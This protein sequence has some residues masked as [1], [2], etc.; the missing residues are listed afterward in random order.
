MLNESGAEITE[1]V[2]AELLQKKREN[3]NRQQEIAAQLMG[4]SLGGGKSTKSQSLEDL[5]KELNAL[6]TDYDSIE[7]QIRSASPRYAALT[8]PRPLTLEDIRQQVLDDQ[9]AL[10]EY[11]LGDERSYLFAVTRNGFT[12]S[13]L[14][15]RAEIERQTAALRAQI[16]PASLRRS[17]TDMVSAAIDPQPGLSVSGGASASPAVASA[18]APAASA[19][20]KTGVEPAAPLFKQSRLLVVA[21]GALNYVPFHALVTE[22]PSG[23]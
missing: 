5:E 11:K 15:G 18:F 4:V 1:G 6:Q 19:L 21:D 16:I 7:N 20:Y 3:Q 23:A 14:P 12:L 17:I 8:A 13:R 2:P 10:L 22:A 9:T